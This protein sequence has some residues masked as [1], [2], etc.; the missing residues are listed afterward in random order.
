MD[1][2]S[3]PKRENLP[4]HNSTFSKG[5]ISSFKESFSGNQ[6]LV[7]QI[8]FCSNSPDLRVASEGC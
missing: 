6:R 2:Q 5:R 4:A 7:F 8:K 3:Q 1:K